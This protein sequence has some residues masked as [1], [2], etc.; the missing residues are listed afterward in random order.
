MDRKEIVAKK[1]QYVYPAVANY[2][3]DPLPLERGEDCSTSGTRT[4]S[5]TSTSSAASSR[6]ASATATPASLARKRPKSI[7]SATP[8]RSTRTKRWWLSP[9]R[10]RR[11]LPAASKNPSSPAPAPRPTRPPST[12]PACTPATSKSSPPPLLL[13][14]L[15]AHQIPH[16]HRGLAQSFLPGRHRPCDEPL[17]LPLSPRQNLS[18]L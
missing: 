9:K 6:S 13:R 17:L 10:S 14:P 1:Q 2:F 5:A 18:L 12:Q 3:S 4:A 16:R 7:S 8:P 15:L 11:S